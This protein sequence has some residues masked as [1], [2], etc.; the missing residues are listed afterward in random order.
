M[1]WRAV[2]IRPYPLL[3]VVAVAL[4]GRSRGVEGAHPA[5]A[6]PQVGGHA[7][8][9]APPLLAPLHLA[10]HHGPGVEHR[11]RRRRRGGGLRLR[12]LHGLGRLRRLGRL[13]WFRNLYLLFLDDLGGLGLADGGV[14]GQA[15]G[16]ALGA[17]LVRQPLFFPC[18]VIHVQRLGPGR[19]RSP[20][21]RKPFTSGNG[22]LKCVG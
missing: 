18:A 13:G 16:D 22:G 14:G 17:P 15:R 21:H 20:R 8:R 3:R 10:L 12:G 7:L 11:R 19:Y 5:L 2:C 4:L 1:T 6:R 9:H